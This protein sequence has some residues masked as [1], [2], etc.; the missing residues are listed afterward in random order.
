VHAPLVLCARLASWTKNIPVGVWPEM[1][2]G[3][4]D[5]AADVWEALLAVADAAGG[6]WPDRARRSA[7]AH[8]ADAK[9]APPSLGVRLLADLQSVFND[10]AIENLGTEEII[11]ALIAMDDAPWADLRGKPLD[12]RGLARR[13]SRYEVKPRN[14]RLGDRIVKGYSSTD[15]SDPWSRYVGPSPIAAATTATPLPESQDEFEAE[16]DFSEE[17]PDDETLSRWADEASTW[18]DEQ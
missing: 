16:F 18:E 11:T 9:A 14:V 4:E 13:L 1:P 6:D 5:R 3:V 12:A 7:V 10:R 8:V 15:L 2:P 17:P